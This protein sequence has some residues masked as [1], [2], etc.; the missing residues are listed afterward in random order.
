MTAPIK[1]VNAHG[2]IAFVRCNCPIWGVKR[3]SLFT[4]FPEVHEDPTEMLCDTHGLVPVLGGSSRCP[5]C[6]Y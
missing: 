3:C 2:C 6:V 5:S 4:N 1:S